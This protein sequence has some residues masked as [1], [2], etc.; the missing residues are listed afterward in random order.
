MDLS[1]R[2]SSPTSA[3]MNE[4]WRHHPL[5]RVN[6]SILVSDPPQSRI[7][8][9]S[10]QAQIVS[11]LVLEQGCFRTDGTSSSGVFLV[12]NITSTKLKCKHA[13]YHPH[14]LEFRLVRFYLSVMRVFFNPGL[15]VD[16]PVG[17]MYDD[18]LQ[19]KARIGFFYLFETREPTWEKGETVEYCA[20]WTVGFCWNVMQTLRLVSR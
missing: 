17:F 13:F 18:H 12:S 7:K 20:L 4:R 9:L 19:F 11:G 14:S 10:R 1:S 5:Q 3:V 6:A 2:I 8:C 16:S 15:S